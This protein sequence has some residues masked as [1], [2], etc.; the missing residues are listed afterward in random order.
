MNMH[1]NAIDPLL[2]IDLSEMYIYILFTYITTVCLFP[3][4]QN[5]ISL[6]II[7]ATVFNSKLSH[8]LK[9]NYLLLRMY[10]LCF[11]YTIQ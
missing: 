9:H 11:L 1:S 4:I 10:Y 2:K 8:V 6:L 7:S 3:A 5:D